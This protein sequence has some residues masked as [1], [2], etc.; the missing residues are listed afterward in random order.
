V[1][2]A[3]AQAGLSAADLDVASAFIVQPEAGCAATGL[4]VK[5]LSAVT[6]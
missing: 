3:Q 6:L 4:G 1:N 5:V 2:I